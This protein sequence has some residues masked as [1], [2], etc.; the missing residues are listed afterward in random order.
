MSNPGP[1]AIN[2]QI[3]LAARPVGAIQ[4]GDWEET[5]EPVGRLE[6]REQIHSGFATFPEALL[7]L[8]AGGNTG[9]LVLAV[10]E[11]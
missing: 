2:H 3:R 4:R 7:E 6:S 11:E 5:T 8:L 1:R 9:R 10:R